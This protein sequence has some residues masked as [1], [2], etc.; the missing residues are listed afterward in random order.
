MGNVIQAA[1]G[2]APARQATLFA[3]KYIVI[4]KNDYIYIF[5]M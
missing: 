1:V 2:Q 4:S 5:T 3:G